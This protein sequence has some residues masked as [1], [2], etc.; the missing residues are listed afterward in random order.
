MIR[1]RD[2]IVVGIGMFIIG[3]FGGM[4]FLQSKHTVVTATNNNERTLRTA[5]D[6]SSPRAERRAIETSS[7]YYVDG[8]EIGRKFN[9]MS[10]RGFGAIVS[11]VR[12]LN[13]VVPTS[14]VTNSTN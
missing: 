8:E 11:V 4:S 2:A 6:E 12:M 10:V 7:A 9:D 14:A 13:K 5:E 1:M 3:L